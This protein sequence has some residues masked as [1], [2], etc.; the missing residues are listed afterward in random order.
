[1][2]FKNVKINKFEDGISGK[3]FRRTSQYFQNMI[4]IKL[5]VYLKILTQCLF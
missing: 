5:T 4:T 3:L 2:E 1:M